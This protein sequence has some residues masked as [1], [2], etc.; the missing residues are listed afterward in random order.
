MEVILKLMALVASDSNAFEG[1]IANATAKIQQLMLRYSI[2]DYELNM[3]KADRE[4]ADY[5]K[6]FKEGASGVK[7]LRTLKWHWD[8]ASLIATVTNTKYFR[9]G[10][11][12]SDI[13]KSAREFYFFGTEQNVQVASQLYTQWITDIANM[14]DAALKARRDELTEK[15]DNN[16]VKAKNFWPN[17]PSEERTL[18]YRTSWIIGCIQGMREAVA[19]EEKTIS[20]TSST[21]IQLYRTEIEKSYE[22]FSK[23][24]KKINIGGG[25]G[26]SFDAYQK[27]K[28]TGKKINIASKRIKA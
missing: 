2:S 28:E 19:V 9:R 3:K 24:F 11:W 21:A 13:Q 4:H 12:K 1:E 15:Y 5:K 18:H 16:H 14:A 26:F 27:G 7:N 23:G 6:I 17:L 8:L 25:R 20:K 10:S 22:D